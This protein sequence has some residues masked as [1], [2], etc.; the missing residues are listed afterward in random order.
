MN[1]GINNNAAEYRKRSTGDQHIN[2]SSLNQDLMQRQ[3][4][5]ISFSAISY[6]IDKL[7]DE[8]HN[9]QREALEA[10]CAGDW[11]K[12][13]S[14]QN[15]RDKVKISALINAALRAGHRAWAIK[16]LDAFDWRSDHCQIL[17]VAAECGDLEMAHLL[18]K[19]R[20]LS[21]NSFDEEAETPVHYAAKNGQVAMLDYLARECGGDINASHKA[22]PWTPLMAAVKANQ[23]STVQYLLDQRAETMASVKFSNTALHIAAENNQVDCIVQLLQHGAMVDALRGEKERNTPL[24]LAC[25]QG[26]FEASLALLDANADPNA[27]N[28]RKETALHLACQVLAQPLIRVLLDRGAC[29][30]ARDMDG[31]TPL[32]HLINSNHKNDG[33]KC[34]KMLLDRGASINQV[35]S[36]GLSPLHIAAIGCKAHHLTSLIENGADLCIKNNAKQSGL[37]FALKYLPRSTTAALITRLDKSILTSSK[38]EGDIETQIKLDMQVLMPPTST[39]SNHPRSEVEL[40]KD[41]LHYNAKPSG[42][43]SLV[44]SV[45]LHPSSQCFLHLKMNQMLKF[46]WLMVV[47]THLV[48]SLTYSTYSWLVYRILCPFDADHCQLDSHSIFTRQLTWTCWILMIIFSTLYMMRE[49]VRLWQNR[50]EYPRDYENWLHI[51][52]NI[53][54]FLT[55]F[56]TSPLHNDEPIVL[57]KWQY[58]A[59][60]VGVFC[61]WLLQMFI[62]GR[63]PRFGLYINVFKKVL[64]TFLNVLAT[65]FF[66]FVAFATSFVALFPE[67]RAFAATPA[68]AL[69][70]VL[71]MMLGEIDYDDLYHPQNGVGSLNNSRGFV[72]EEVAESVTYP[73][74]SLIMITIFIILVS[75]VIMN[76]LFGLAVADIQMVFKEARIRQL[77]QQIQLIAFM[78]KMLVIITGL[79]FIL[80][81]L[82][83][84]IKSQLLSQRRRGRF[85]KLSSLINANDITEEIAALIK[86]KGHE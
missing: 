47:F 41:L 68:S 60:G 81:P 57:A 42:D 39:N 63:I 3:S 22:S 72:I 82:K 29:F 48:Y 44:E 8:R 54:F 85:V 59:N 53:C 45:L 17:H 51:V 40:F 62:I 55:S 27:L 79:P 7:L 24:H 67:H 26:F 69:I 58:Q 49:L 56:H 30:E 13:E 78:E 21:A 25:H 46:Y 9:A 16:A 37:Q 70:K 23:V 86:E 66:L 74:I 43:S 73:V 64:L 84:F 11:E 31:R 71:V 18:V 5:S 32:H 2:L 4:S 77:I 6:V 10:V 1:G 76:L 33:N 36:H 75:V 52:T 19:E 20:G 83:E 50:W 14:I 35:D 61:T 15:S 80:R 38:I 12:I 34:M 28:G 65:F